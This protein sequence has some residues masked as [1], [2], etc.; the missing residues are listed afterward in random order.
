MTTKEQ[1]ITALKADFPTIRVGSEEIGYT[2]LV[3]KDYEN[4]IAEWADNA[5][6]KEQ[7]E[8]DQAAKVTA[9]LAIL[10]KLGLTADEAALLLG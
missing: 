3:G 10:D 5:I 1:K 8:L 7:A 2:E 9:R 4:L 6:A